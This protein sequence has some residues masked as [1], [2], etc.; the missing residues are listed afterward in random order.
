MNRIVK[1]RGLYIDGTWI[2][3]DLVTHYE[4]EPE[5]VYIVDEECTYHKVHNK[6]IGQF[7]GF[8]DKNGK[9]VFEGDILQNDIDT[10]LFNWLIEYS[11]GGF[12]ARNIGVD[13]YLMKPFRI[14][15]IDL[16]NRIFVGN[17]FSNPELLKQVKP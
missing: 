11:D 6:T 1:F 16:I 9:E 15:H 17:E 8:T 14:N 10:G 4:N 7:T 5:S 12:A 2:Y 3:G 13:G